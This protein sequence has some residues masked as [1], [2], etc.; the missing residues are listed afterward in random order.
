M[1]LEGWPSGGTFS[2]PINQITGVKHMPASNAVKSQQQSKGASQSGRGGGQAEMEMSPTTDIMEYCK[3]YARQ[4]PEMM[5][6]WCFG[7]GF[8]LGWKLKPW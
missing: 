7:I 1:S 8:V 6:L 2:I 4:K 5:A 3:E